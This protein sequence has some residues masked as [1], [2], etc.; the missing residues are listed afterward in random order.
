M[1]DVGKSK[2]QLFAAT[3]LLV[4]LVLI[5]VLLFPE[6]SLRGW[7]VGG[8]GISALALLLGRVM[9]CRSWDLFVVWVISVSSIVAYLLHDGLGLI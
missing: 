9:N 3:I 5:L 6:S 1:K 8:I 4:V 7:V 2:S